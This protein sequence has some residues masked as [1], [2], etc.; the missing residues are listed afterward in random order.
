MIK[1]LF[2]FLTKLGVILAIVGIFLLTTSPEKAIAENSLE[3]KKLDK[4]Q[5]KIASSYSSKF[6]NGIGIGI[7]KEG[8]TRLTITEN[9]ESKFNPSL[10]FELATS[11]KNNIEKIDE[12]QVL[13]L[14]SKKII[15]EI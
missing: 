9:K 1:K 13:D 5:E 10:W 14:L 3:I 15:R 12:S 6:C 8:S 7:S 4:L 11:G 2:S